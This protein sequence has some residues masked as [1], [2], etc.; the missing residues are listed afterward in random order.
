[1]GKLTLE[2]LEIVDAI[3]RRGSFSA[4]AEVLHKV[5]STIS[6]TVAKLEDD[7]KVALFR[8]NGPRIE[9][10][11]AGRELLRE[12]RLLLQAASD[13][14][15]RVKRVASGWESK[16]QIAVDSLISTDALT[17]L[18]A[19]FH[20]AADA[21][22]LS[23]SEETLTGT[24]E[25]LLDTRSDLVIAAGPGPAGGGY[26]AKEVAKLEFWFCVAPF[27]PLAKADEPLS[28]AQV[29]AYRA[30][31]VGDSARRLPLRTTG[32][33]SGQATIVVPGMR[34]KFR[35]Q[36][37]GLGVG[38][39]PA[40]CAEEAVNAGLLVRK[41]V[42][43]ERSPETLSVAWRVGAQGNALAWWIERL[44][45]SRA[46]KAILNSSRRAYASSGARPAAGVRRRPQ[47][48]V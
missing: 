43:S 9:I 1:M 20:K 34:A 30:V 6:Y 25:S 36:V 24:W 8:R 40:L 45:E 4:A 15:C 27:H 32:L 28:E 11:E 17:P 22:S 31:V 12:G 5:P 39:L 42:E 35:L 23:I 18:I 21:T 26:L 29:R 44:A 2:G 41:Q 10:T 3:D 14:E 13:L 46:M 33:L 37:E 47:G 19:Q 48:K 7:L 16:F 38:H